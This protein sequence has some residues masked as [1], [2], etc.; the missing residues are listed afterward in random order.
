MAATEI[1][2]SK[3]KIILP[4]RRV[5]LLSRARLLDT[6]YEF[7]DRRLIMVSAPAGYGKTSLLIDLAHHSELPFCWLALDPLDSDPQRF[8]AYFVA[9]LSERFPKFGGRSRSLLNGLTNFE[10]EMERL[11][12]TLVNEIYD[13]I[14]EHFVLVLDDFHL[15]DEVEQ[16]HYFVN[17]FTQLVGENCHLILSSRSLP[18]LHDMPLLVAREQVGGL[19]FSDLAFRPDEIQALLAQNRQIHLS[20]DDARKLVEATEGW[21]TGLQFTDLNQVQA[22]T[23]SSKTLHGVGVSVFDYLG[24]QVLK[25]Q[26]KDLQI[27]MLRSSLLEEFDVPMCE[28]VLGP[29]YSE[30]QDWSR[31]LET[32]SQKNLFALPV[33][34]NGQWL[35]YHHLFRDYLQECIRR[36][37]PEEVPSIL[38]CLAQFYE[39]RG[40]WERAYQLYK[41]LGDVNS[42]ADMIERAGIPMYQNAMLTLDSWLKNLPPSLLNT[43]AGLLSL[44]GAV[45]HLK[46][47]AAGAAKLLDHAIK[48]FRKDNDVPGLSQAL[49]RR[50]HAYQFIGNYREAIQDAQ[51]VLQLTEEDDSLQWVY[52]EALRIKGLSL[53]RQGITLQASDYLERALDIHLRLGNSHFIPIL[54]M[55]IGTVDG[56]LGKYDETKAAFEKALDFWR[57]KGN[58]SWQANV[59]NNLGVLHQKI[60]EYEQSAHVLEEGLLCAQRSGYKRMEAYITMGLGD[61]YSKLEDFEIA[62][63]NYQRANELVQQ[64]G[65]RFL[66]NYLALMEANLSLL[67]Q[68]AKQARHILELA[69]NTVKINGSNYERGYYQ[70]LHGRLSILEGKT[71]QAITELAEAKRCFIQE[72]REM[73]STWSRVWLAAAYC[74]NGELL[75]AIEEMKAVLPSPNQVSHAAIV[76]AR[77]A[78]DWLA[79]LRTDR[80]ARASLR[81]LFEKADQLGKQLPRIRRQLR[82][83]AHTIEIPSP[84]LIIRAFGQSEVWVNGTLVTASEWQRQ[85]VR[86]LFFFLLATERPLTKEQIGEVLWPG[87]S[88]SGKFKMRFKNEIYRLRRAIGQDVILFENDR[89]CFNSAM[90]HE[91]DVEA[92]E[93][94][95]A[96]AKTAPTS[97]EQISYYQK[98]IDLVRG[99]YLEDIGAVWVWPE[100]EQLRQAFFSASLALA[101]LHT[102]AGQTPKA[103]QICQRILESEPTFEAAYRLMMQIYSR[104]GDKPSIVHLYQN[105]DKAMRNTFGLPPSEET[106]KLYLKLIS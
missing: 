64:L 5:E 41:Q 14:N 58:L 90:N 61:L 13:E 53:F 6:L 59:L 105:C 37:Y 17:R 65:E 30:P 15:L 36:D 1:P 104:K 48:I 55:E 75:P 88:E 42:L 95:L 56:T 85:S 33:G 89:Y 8:V 101:E 38:G 96:K 81:I 4:R 93:A 23:N 52:A 94:F 47:N 45:E 29:L 86:E 67:Q 62:S 3:T 51:E 50:G 16:I 10:E 70:L 22:G 27:F 25:N 19:D 73:E 84:N 91:Y 99:D 35:R 44:R 7:L 74:Q 26:P 98:A 57:Q 78:Y 80:K 83:M 20:D 76:T 39:K 82:R 87:T 28:A 54:L 24:Q 12:V 21:I 66:I 106:E 60:G 103:L 11:L 18:D 97:S 68:N 71:Q 32:I 49:M 77:Q 63:Q 34:A 31:Y 72:G 2:I 40:D 46:G 9:A 43:R 69:E 79:D 100:R 92:F 102:K